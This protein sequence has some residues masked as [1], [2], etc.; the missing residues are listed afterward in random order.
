MI[1]YQ[2]KLLEFLIK[3]WE[4]CAEVR[5]SEQ[6]NKKIILEKHKPD[7]PL[8]LLIFNHH[9]QWQQ[10]PISLQKKS[11]CSCFYF[12]SAKNAGYQAKYCDTTLQCDHSK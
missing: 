4:H 12:A 7:F 11:D 6:A 9:P 2:I 1:D 10:A 8:P 3:Q 5:K